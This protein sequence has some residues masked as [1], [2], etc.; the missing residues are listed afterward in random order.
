MKI[1]RVDFISGVT[2]IRW[3]RMGLDPTDVLR[4][5]D[6]KEAVEEQEIEE[7][8]YLEERVHCLENKEVRT[9]R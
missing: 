4:F 1:R 9:L 3:Q 2:K 8:I 7:K 6:I 5:P